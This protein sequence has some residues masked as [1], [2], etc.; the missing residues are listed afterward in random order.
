MDAFPAQTDQ[1]FRFK[2]IVTNGDQ[3]GGQAWGT[4][5]VSSAI[6]RVNGFEVVGPQDLSLSVDKI[7][8]P[9]ELEEHNT[10][11]AEI[12]GM[13]ASYLT[14]QVAYDPISQMPKHR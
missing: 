11:S 5:R 12:W 2:L 6:I 7:E 13:P 8:I 9:L 14:V 3:D 1:G 4:R 10:I